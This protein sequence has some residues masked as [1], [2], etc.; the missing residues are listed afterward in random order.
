MP[1]EHLRRDYEAFLRGPVATK[2]FA[3]GTVDAYR[4]GVQHHGLL[5]I[6]P[7]PSDGND[8]DFGIVAPGGFTVEI[9]DEGDQDWF[10]LWEDG[11][12]I[13]WEDMTRIITEY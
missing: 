10:L 6:F 1:T 12:Y 4:S 8:D 2:T 7:E 9:A 3:F 13:L 11:T 5:A